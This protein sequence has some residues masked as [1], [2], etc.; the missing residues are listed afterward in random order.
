MKA[1]G[2]THDLTFRSKTLVYDLEE[3]RGN[4][5]GM[6][7]AAEALKGSPYAAECFRQ[8]EIAEANAK[9]EAAKQGK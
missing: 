7:T 3:A 9:T 1:Y 2:P 5:V 6:R 4:L 8:L